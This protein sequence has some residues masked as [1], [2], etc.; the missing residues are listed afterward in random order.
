[1]Q[2][3]HQPRKPELEQVKCPRCESTNTKFCYYNN[4]SLTQPRYFCKSCR[5]YWTN[6]GPLRNVPV[7]GDTRKAVKYRSVGVSPP[8]KAEPSGLNFGLPCF[9]SS[10]SSKVEILIYCIFKSQFRKWFIFY[11]ILWSTKLSIWKVSRDDC[12]FRCFKNRVLNRP[13]QVIG[14]WV[15]WQKHPKIPNISFE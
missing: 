4:Y 11:F 9:R 14:H 12:F 10:G 1:M 8:V 5:K 2:F 13:D 3:T 15:N 6:A 7:G